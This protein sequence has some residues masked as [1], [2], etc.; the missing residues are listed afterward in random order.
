MATLLD[1]DPDLAHVRSRPVDREDEVKAC[2]VHEIPAADESFL[3]IRSDPGDRS[4][5]I[6]PVDSVSS[7]AIGSESTEMT[8]A[9]SSVRKFSI[10]RG[11]SHSSFGAG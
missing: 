1:F 5:V 4:A 9:R 8:S 2:P 3:R 10:N 7:S 6:E 11:G